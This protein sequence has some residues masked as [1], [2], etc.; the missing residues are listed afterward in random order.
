MNNKIDVPLSDSAVREALGADTR[1]LKYSELKN[2]KTMAE[3]LPTVNSFFICLLEE[4]QN[5]GHWTC[6]MRLKKNY[7]YFN[8]YGVKYDA[9]ISVVPRCIRRILDED[10]ARQFKRL[11]GGRKCD[12]NRVQVQGETSQTCGRWVVLAIVFCCFLGHLPAEL[13]ELVR[14]KSKASGQSFDAIVC[15]IVNI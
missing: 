3:L 11:L 8:S 4:E 2:Y 15:Q 13:V 10:P 12:W 14:D 1:I 6:M 7:F 5:R 9:D